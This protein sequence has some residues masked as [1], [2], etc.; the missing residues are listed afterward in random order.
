M[1]AVRDRAVRRSPADRFAAAMRAIVGRLP[2]G[3]AG[4]VAPSLVGF[5]LLNSLTFGIDLALLGTLHG[6]AHWPL[7]AAIS[8][9]YATAFA[10]NFALNR[11]LNF[12][13]HGALGPQVGVYALVVALNYLLWILGFADVL[14]WAGVDYRLARIAAGACEAAYM[15]AALRWVVFR[16]RANRAAAHGSIEG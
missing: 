10:L 15:Y 8:L 1:H 14:A 4:R 5:L 3:L 16:P 11:A 6:V 9:A 7:P 2:F 13:V 12:R